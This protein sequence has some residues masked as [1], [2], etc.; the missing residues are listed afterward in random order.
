MIK[1]HETREGLHSLQQTACH[2]RKNGA[3]RPGSREA[4]RSRAGPWHGACWKIP[5]SHGG[6]AQKFFGLA[7]KEDLNMAISRIIP[8]VASISAG[9]AQELPGLPVEDPATLLRRLMAA[10]LDHIPLPGSG[11]TLDRWRLLAQVAACNLGLSKLYEGHTDALAIMAELD[12]PQPPALSMWGVWCSQAPG[13]P[14]RIIDAHS[15]TPLPSNRHVQLSGSKSWCSGARHVSHALVSA[16]DDQERSCLAAVAIEQ[17]GVTV[18]DKGWHAVGMQQSAS[19]DVLFDNAD[20]VLVG[21]PGAYTG[22]PGFWHGAAGVAACW[23]G[24]LTRIAEYVRE[25]NRRRPDPYR[26]AHLG[27]IDA[28]LAGCRQVLRNTARCIDAMP[29]ESSRL[30]VFRARLCVEAAAEDT[31]QRAARA[32][33]AG[34]LCR[35]A[36]FARVMADLPVFIRQSH[37]EHDQAEHGGQVQEE[38]CETL[39]SL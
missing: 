17:P 9:L 31:V 38:T 21:A 6:K 14:L 22:R 26:A 3:A 1:R 32:L 10:G 23:Y 35:D 19:V 36:V 2:S 27:A 28:E 20:A 34:P 33:G 15:S 5:A 39:W 24:A 11:R 30:D 4:R 13:V 16:C 37:A 12:A 18:T 7:G 25:S 29:Q 8:G